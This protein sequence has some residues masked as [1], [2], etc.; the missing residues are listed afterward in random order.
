[1][2]RAS[3]II[4]ATAMIFRITLAI[5][6]I[7]GQRLL[8]KNPAAIMDSS[9]PNDNAQRCISCHPDADDQRRTIKIASAAQATPATTGDHVGIGLG[10][11][12]RAMRMYQGKIS[13]MV[14]ST[15]RQTRGAL[16]EA[17]L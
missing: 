9:A 13:A 15:I 14:V 4:P 10:M 2:E 1:M 8:P 7:R 3:P 5:T 16:R 17:G 6:S 11:K 12:S